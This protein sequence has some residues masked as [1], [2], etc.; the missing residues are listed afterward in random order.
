MAGRSQILGHSHH[1]R[2]LS[3]KLGSSAKGQGLERPRLLVFRFPVL[4]PNL[5][6]LAELR[7]RG[8]EMWPFYV[9]HGIM[10]DYCTEEDCSSYS[11]FVC[12]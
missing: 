7:Q 5:C 4:P 1:S 9:P 2:N 12:I 3:L 6:R 10:E 11:W 8:K